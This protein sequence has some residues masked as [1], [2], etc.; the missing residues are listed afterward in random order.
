MKMPAMKRN[1]H[2]VLKDAANQPFQDNAGDVQKL[3]VDL[4]NAI[5]QQPGHD[6]A[7]VVAGFGAALLE[8]AARNKS[9]DKTLEETFA[10]IL[11]MMRIYTEQMLMDHDD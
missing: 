10:Q 7:T 4:M 3:A 11:T 9:E 8:F 6:R 2:N 1:I 5:M